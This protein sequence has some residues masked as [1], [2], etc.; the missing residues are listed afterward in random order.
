MQNA[1]TCSTHFLAGCFREARRSGKAFRNGEFQRTDIERKVRHSLFQTSIVQFKIAQPNDDH[2]AVVSEQR[3]PPVEGLHG[4]PMGLT[5]YG[6]RQTSVNLSQNVFY[7][8]I[9]KA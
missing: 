1:P 9:G 2:A 4:N 3:F 6:W 7:F 5:N 8:I